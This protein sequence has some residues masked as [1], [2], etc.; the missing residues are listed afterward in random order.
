MEQ[1]VDDP[2]A[3][4]PTSNRSNSLAFFGPTP[5]RAPAGANRGSRMAGAWIAPYKPGAIN[6]A[7]ASG[8]QQAGA[9]R[10][11]DPV[12]LWLAE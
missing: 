7:S 5:G 6:A 8:G 11:D 4:R 9:R 2:R 1:Y 3:L 12:A 10:F